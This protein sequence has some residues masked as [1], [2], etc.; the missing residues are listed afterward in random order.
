METGR[1]IKDFIF[2]D[3]CLDLIRKKNLEQEIKCND[4]GNHQHSH[5]HTSTDSAMVPKSQQPRKV[6]ILYAGD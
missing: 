4:R 5:M 1:F 2:Q 3:N 6:Q